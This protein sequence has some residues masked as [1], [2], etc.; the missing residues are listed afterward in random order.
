MCQV[1]CHWRSVL[2]PQPFT[3][4]IND[5]EDGIKCMVAKFADDI[6]TTT[7][8]NL[9]PGVS[10]VS[11]SDSNGTASELVG[12]QRDDDVATEQDKF[13][14]SDFTLGRV[15]SPAECGKGFSNSSDLQK[16]KRVHTGKRPFSCYEYGK[17]FS[18]SFNLLRHQREHT[19]ARPFT[20]SQC[21]KGFSQL[22]NL[23]THQQIHTKERLFTCSECGK[24]F[25][26]SS[27]L[28]KHKRVH[29][30]E[31]PFTCSDFG[32]GFTLAKTP[33]SSQ[34]ITG[35]GFCCYCCC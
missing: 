32:K 3:I 22:S 31:R 34:V 27:D 33:A 29:T 13:H 1:E 9:I 28:Q 25:A 7:C 4:Y 21:G 20:C 5:L 2:G 11:L 18:N 26:Q 35:V 23:Q 16:H 10:W 6:D 30:R 24:G 12:Q 15:S 17:G 14:T 8:G 19:G